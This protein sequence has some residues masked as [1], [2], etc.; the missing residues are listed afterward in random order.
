[1]LFLIDKPVLIQT[2][3]GVLNKSNC[4]IFSQCSESLAQLAL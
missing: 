1:V 3:D 4:H 2:T